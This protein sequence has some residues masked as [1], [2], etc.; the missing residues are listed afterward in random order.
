MDL[1]LV[2]HVEPEEQQIL[3]Q[4]RQSYPVV[5]DKFT[6]IYSF[7]RSILLVSKCEIL[8]LLCKFIVI[9]NIFPDGQM[10]GLNK[11]VSMVYCTS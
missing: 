6:Q 1:N 5:R 8:V 11:N 10:I 4:L 3:L 7:V 9:A 2:S